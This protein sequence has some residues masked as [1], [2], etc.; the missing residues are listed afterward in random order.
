MCIRDSPLGN[1]LTTPLSLY[2]WA[3][4]A[5]PNMT[6]IYSTE[7]EYTDHA[8]RLKPRFNKARCLPGSRSF[9]SF[10]PINEKKISCK[11]VSIS[12]TSQEFEIQKKGKKKANS[13]LK[14]K[15]SIRKRKR[16]PMTSV[17]Q[18]RA[19]E[20]VKKPRRRNQT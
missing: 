6:F 1:Q 17:T 13:R 10:I 18:K 2:E 15:T 9:H 7:D 12:E 5:L 16:K 14:T 8:K 3:K 4:E 19:A 20:N 11:A